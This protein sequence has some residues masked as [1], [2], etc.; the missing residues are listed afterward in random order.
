MRAK[1]KQNTS[2]F[3]K[4]KVIKTGKYSKI[5]LTF[6]LVLTAIFAG[7]KLKHK[8]LDIFANQIL[9]KCAKEDS[10]S[11]CY[12]IEIPKLLEKKLVTMEEAFKVTEKIQS[13]DRTYLYCHTLGHQLADIETKKDPSKWLDV[14]ARCPA[15][16]C[17]NGCPHGA[18]QRRF[19]GSDVLT[20]AQITEIMPDLNIVC[21]ERKGFNPTDVERFMCYHSLGHLAMYIT[22]ADIDKSLEICKKVGVKDESPNNY[23][24]TCTQGV[25]MIIY[26]SLDLEDAALVEAVK[27]KKE[28]IPNFCRRFK[29]LEFIACRTEAWIS[30]LTEFKDP[31][32]IVDFCAFTKGGYG[33]QWCYSTTLGLIP[34]QLLNNSGV[35]AVRDYCLGFPKNIQ[36]PCFGQVSVDWVQDEPGYA[37]DAI[38]FC[39]M[40]EEKGLSGMCWHNLL[41][42]SKWSFQPQS[43][44]W[45][46]YCGKFP[47]PQRGKCFAGDVPDGYF[48]WAK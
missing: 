19:K 22:G 10:K 35:T 39:N 34:L 16:S 45:K 46:D 2:N 37:E 47:E 13:A 36:E 44:D 6:T 26:Q 32:G 5:I 7:G 3:A 33:T 21:E 17:N 8:N 25:F 9:E 11:T 30:F 41:F 43:A 38:T 29:D 1:L 12:D 4:M 18:I 20:D 27:P 24:Q 14:V 42:F 48:E 40:A 28:D 15:L 23:Y 31:S